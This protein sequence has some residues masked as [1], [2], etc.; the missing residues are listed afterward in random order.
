[1]KNIMFSVN[2]V[3]MKPA[4]SNSSTLSGSTVQGKFKWEN[5]K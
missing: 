2:V 3:Q 1:M 5:M 4:T